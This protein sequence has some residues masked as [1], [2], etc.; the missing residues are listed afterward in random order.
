MRAEEIMSASTPAK[1]VWARA[2]RPEVPPGLRIKFADGAFLDFNCEGHL[3]GHSHG[4]GGVVQMRLLRRD[5]VGREM[6]LVFESC[7]A[8]TEKSV[9]GAAPDARP[10][11]EVEL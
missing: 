7:P 4:D 11:D 5:D 3:I 10:Q 1:T 2:D 6:H 9:A 8:R